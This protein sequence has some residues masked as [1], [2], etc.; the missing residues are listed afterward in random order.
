MHSAKVSKTEWA[1]Y[2]MVY[3][4]VVAFIFRSNDENLS[5]T[6]LITWNY[7]LPVLLYST[8]VMLFILGFSQVLKTFIRKKAVVLGLSISIGLI[9][10]LKS[11]L[12]VTHWIFN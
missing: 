5:F 10:G 2:L 11:L 6:E 4:L 7:G 1:I 3:L 12:V 9:L 8:F